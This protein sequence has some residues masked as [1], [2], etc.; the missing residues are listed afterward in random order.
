M[1]PQISVLPSRALCD[2]HL[3]RLPTR[4]EL[5]RHVALL[6]RRHTH[7]ADSA[8][9]RHGWQIDA[10]VLID[11][12]LAVRRPRDGVIPVRLR[13]LH[14]ASAVE[15]DSIVVSEVRVLT[16]DHATGAEVDL[17]IRNVDAVHAAHDPLA[18]RHLILHAARDAVVQIEMRPPV[19]LGHPEHF[20]A[21]V[22]VEAPVAA[23]VRDVGAQWT[24]R[25]KRRRLVGHHRPRFAARRVH[26]DDAIDLMSALV[27]LERERAPILPPHGLRD[28]V[29][30]WKERIVDHRTCPRDS[31]S[32]TTGC[33]KSRSVAGLPVENRRVFRLQL[34]GR[35]RENVVHEAVVPGP[36]PIRDE[37]LRVRRPP[38]RH[39]LV[40]VTLGAVKAQQ[41]CRPARAFG[42]PR[43]P[44]RPPRPPPAPAVAGSRA[45]RVATL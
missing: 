24:V 23:V 18:L 38:N 20:L 3:R 21:V 10:R 28:L 30:A 11:E 6:E 43:P 25:E 27:V 15:I 13:V 29:C 32:K 9:L 44:P 45:G 35:R 37:L 22:H 42:A 14:Q 33:T 26:L 40:R 1:M 16:R 36:P 5:R 17:P 12:V 2:E 31:T 41:S 7:V 4:R 34:I 19:A 8:E 39:Q